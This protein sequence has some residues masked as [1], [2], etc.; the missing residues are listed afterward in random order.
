[1][2]D[3]PHGYARYR[4]DGCRCYI[5]AFARSEYDENRNR[6][7][8]YGTWNPWVDAEPVRKHIRSVQS[9]GVGLRRIGDAAGVTRKRLQSILSGRPERGTGPQERVR[10]AIA[11][12]ILAVQPT[13]DLMGPATPIGSTGTVRRLQA[14]VAAGWPQHHLAVALGQKDGNFTA[15]L[16]RPQVLVR[17]AQAVRALYDRLWKED[18][19]HHGV[20]AQAYSRARNQAASRGWAPF[21]AWDDDTIDDPATTP[22]YGV[23]VPQYLA[24]AEN[25]AELET[26]GFTRQN[27]AQRLG[28]TRGHLDKAISLTRK[29]AKASA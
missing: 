9:C 18:P 17:N 20:G 21:G 19:R 8:A 27:A 13:L 26:Q 29:A 6:A 2:T 7:I 5:C 10:P 24:L 14:L 15:F 3:R 22:D 28:V 4:L 11:A 23:E 25:C 12:A 16:T 1:M